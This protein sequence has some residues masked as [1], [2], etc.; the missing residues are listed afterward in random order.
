M[1]KQT[2]FPAA[3]NSENVLHFLNINNASLSDEFNAGE[4]HLSDGIPDGFSLHSDGVY[5][6]RPCENE[7]QVLVKVCSPLIVKGR[8]RRPDRTGWGSVIGLKDPDGEW[9]ELTLDASVISGSPATVVK[10]LLDLGL[11]L[12]NA[13]KA[14]ESVKE[15]LAAWQ[16]AVRYDRVNHLGWVDS[17]YTAFT[18][19]DGRVVGNARVVPDRISDHVA[20]AMYAKG[21]LDEWRDSVAAP[22]AGNPLMIFALSLAFSGPLL[23]VLGREGGGFHLRGASSSGKSTLQKLAASVWGAPAFKQTWRSTDNAVEGVA[24]ACNGT[25]LLL[26]E[27]HQVD[28]RVAGD[29]VYMLANGAGKNRAQSDGK[30]QG[31]M[32]WV[33]PVLSSGEISLEEHMNSGGRKIQAGQ[34]V[35]LVD[36]VSDDRRH[37]AFDTLHDAPDGDAFAKRIE[38]AAQQN[39]GV[40]GPAFVEHLIP[41]TGKTDIFGSFVKKF[42][43]ASMANVDI[44]SNGQ[45][46]RVLGRFASVALAGELATKFDLTGWRRGDARLAA[47]ELFEIWFRERDA[48]TSAEISEAVDRTRAYVS[49]N[50]DRFPPIGNYDDKTID[51]W[52]DDEW[53]YLLPECWKEIHAGVDPVEAAQFHKADSLLKTQGNGGL[54]VKMGRAVKGRPRAYAVRASALLSSPEK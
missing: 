48:P 17:G 23:A 53:V 31:T 49:Q 46:H 13:T 1:T 16:P 42:C 9:H 30:M 27:L 25:L 43:D 51:G 38:R 18:L 21:T 10:H 19:G 3:A 20:A 28:P 54:Q 47:Q 7:D 6:L 40:A 26:D 45:V 11:V 24:A 29:I 22:C 35:R 4:V 34:D 37:G 14:A 2:D 15:L 8:C 32:R 41:K 52:R 33:V 12:T 44:A 36:V 39:F 50:L 5:Q